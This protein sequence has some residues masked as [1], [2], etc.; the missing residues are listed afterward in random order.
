MEQLEHQNTPLL[1]QGKQLIIACNFVESPANLG[2]ISR[3]A[4]AFGV[5]QILLSNANVSFLES[6]RFKRTARNSEKQIQFKIIDSLVEEI[7]NFKES[8]FYIL[9]LEWTKESLPIQK[10][11]LTER[12][13]LVI[14]NENSGIP[15]SVLSLC[16]QA[17]HIPQFGK[18]SSINVAQALGI[19]LYEISR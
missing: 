10:M 9:A 2:M 4:E 12:M 18:N 13:L 16:S 7:V 6:N 11:K 3:N 8:G 14:G 5:Q 17:I 19:C 1:K 15:D